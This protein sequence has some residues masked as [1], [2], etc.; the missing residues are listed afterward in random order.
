MIWKT[1][2]N[3][4]KICEVISNIDATTLGNAVKKFCASNESY[5]LLSNIDPEIST[6]SSG[7]CWILADAIQKGFGG[8]LVAIYDN[9]IAQHVLIEMNGTF[10]D[11][12]GAATSIKLLHRWKRWE[13]RRNP[14]IGPF[15]PI[16]IS[17]DI[18]R[19]KDPTDII[20]GISQYLKGKS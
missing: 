3:N 2:N 12:D 1:L 15:D 11:S 8:T 4:M 6:W 18:P 17:E 5:Q 9:G 14:K 7:G 16:T 19:P 20:H 10:I 13:M